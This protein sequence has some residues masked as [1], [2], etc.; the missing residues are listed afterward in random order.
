MLSKRPS[1]FAAKAMELQPLQP[2]EGTQV[3][4][5]TGA[6]ILQNES[7][8]T[9]PEVALRPL[10]GP[11]EC[12]TDSFTDEENSRMQMLFNG[13]MCEEMKI[14]EGYQNVACLIIKWTKTLDQLDSGNEITTE[15]SW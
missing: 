11:T 8:H 13:T 7:L 6:A 10:E 4:N 9:L 14:P 3:V 2:L 1:T 15:V 12:S 5:F